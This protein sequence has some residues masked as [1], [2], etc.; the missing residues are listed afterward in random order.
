MHQRVVKMFSGL[1]IAIV[2]SNMCCVSFARTD[3]D[4]NSNLDRIIVDR[5]EGKY[6]VC[7][8]ESGEMV[9]IKVSKFKT[10]PE[11]GDVFRKNSSG[12]YVKDKS[13]TE[14]IKMKIINRFNSLFR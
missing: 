12:K 13:T 9:E 3:N 6:A 14:K 7:E 11:D 2:I 1:L 5:I 8:A 10:K 4:V